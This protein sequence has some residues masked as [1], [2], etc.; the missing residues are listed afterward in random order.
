MNAM[1]MTLSAH[2]FEVQGFLGKIAESP[3]HISM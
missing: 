2:G 3:A 1:L